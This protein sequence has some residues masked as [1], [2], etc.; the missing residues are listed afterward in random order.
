MIDSN[1]MNTDNNRTTEMRYLQNRGTENSRP[2]RHIDRF[3]SVSCSEIPRLQSLFHIRIIIHLQQSSR[4]A[5]KDALVPQL[6]A[7]CLIPSSFIMICECRLLLLIIQLQTV[8][9]PKLSYRFFPGFAT[10]R[11]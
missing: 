6:A 2:I 1:I 8:S 7:C 4:G 9:R 5:P 11:T 3:H 10:D